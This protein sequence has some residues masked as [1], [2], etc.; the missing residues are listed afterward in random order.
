MSNDRLRGA[1]ATVLLLATGAANAGG[2][3][4]LDFELNDLTL[5][6]VVAK[7]TAR[8]ESLAPLLR[9]RLG[10]HFGLEI[11][12]VDSM[13][14]A[15]A[16]EG[17]GYLFEHHDV[18]AELGNVVGADWVVV[19]RLHKPSHLFAYL[20]AQIVGVGSRRLLGRFVVEVKGTRPEL[21]RRGVDALALQLADALATL[22]TR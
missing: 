22:E 14:Q 19:G 10:K 6:P 18:V 9:E 11:V 12:D 2:T 1:A 8:A 21:T 20:E 17:L 16:N 4:V 7:E 15:T 5:N 3:A 13:T